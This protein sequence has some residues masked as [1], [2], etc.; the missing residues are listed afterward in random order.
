MNKDRVSKFNLLTQI[1][2]LPMTRK[3]PLTFLKQQEQE[4]V[5]ESDYRHRRR[6]GLSWASPHGGNLLAL[7][8]PSEVVIIGARTGRLHYRQRH[9][10][11]KKRWRDRRPDEGPEVWQGRLPGSVWLMYDLFNIARKDGVLVW[12]RDRR[13][14]KSAAGNTRSDK[15][16]HAVEFI[17]TICA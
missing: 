10:D 1:R 12:A 3:G 17:Q 11:D 13:P 7:W 4:F 14:A 8:Q 9:G 16:H 15:D 6:V 2:P 5:R